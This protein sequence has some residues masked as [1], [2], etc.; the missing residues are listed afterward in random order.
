[1]RRPY[2]DLASIG[3]LLVGCGDGTGPDIPPATVQYQF[4]LAA[5]GGDTTPERARAYDC[6][7]YGFFEVPVPVAPDGIVRF[8]ITVERR[9]FETRGSHS[10]ATLADS[11]ISEGV[12]E[13]T[14]LGQDSLR[15]ALAAGPYNIS[16]GPGVLVPDPPPEY[17]GAWTCGS[18]VP[19]AQDSTLLAYGYDA[20]ITMPGTWRVSEIQPFE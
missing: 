3:I 10:E 13:Y 14:G 17:S 7:L 16:L 20:G 8:P 4:A 5:F 12:L 18:D 11:S 19:L 9:W 1:M 6:F 2:L 15:F